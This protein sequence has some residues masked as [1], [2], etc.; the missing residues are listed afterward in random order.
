MSFAFVYGLLSALLYGGT[1]L[2]ARL[3]GQRVGV[4]RTV[5]YAQ[6]GSTLVLS[7]ILA[8]SPA[9]RTQALG[10]PPQAWLTLLLTNV[11]L[12]A[13][14]VF[15][16]RGLSTGAI[17]VVAP[18]TAAYG[19]VTAGL[20]LAAG[21]PFSALTLLGM[22]VTVLGC[23]LSATPRRRSADEPRVRSGFG[24]AL[25][26]AVGFGAGFW[27]QG[28]YATP[29]FGVLFPVWSYYCTGAFTAALLGLALR[30]D[31][32]PPSV[33]DLKLVASV[34]AMGTSGYLAL[35]AGFATGQVAVVTVLS[36]TASAVTVL[37]AALW[38]KEPVTRL[39]WL[40]VLLVVLGLALIHA[41][42]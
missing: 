1:D 42:H 21:E 11:I 22:A 27:L 35:T 31:I 3:A 30:R 17:A 6:S 25:A 7:L 9:V 23:A 32:R 34:S 36:T 38:L 4:W 28:R 29:A 33:P 13:S 5:L 26:S 20:S 2:V 14:T 39:Q 37:L 8:F 19:A 15:L 41:R 12:L 18:V 24:W 16:Y 10:A 40:G